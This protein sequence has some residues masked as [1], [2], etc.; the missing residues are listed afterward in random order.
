ML[1]LHSSYRVV[2]NLMALF[3]LVMEHDKLNILYFSRTYNNSNLELDLLTIGAH[4][5]KPKIY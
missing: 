2:T 5:L 4:T 3:G 1:E